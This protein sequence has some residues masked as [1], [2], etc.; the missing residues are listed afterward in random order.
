MHDS[1]V[2]ANTDK[3][4]EEFEVI[5]DFEDTPAVGTAEK[6]RSQWSDADPAQHDWHGKSR[7]HDCNL[8]SHDRRHGNANLVDLRSGRRKIDTRVTIGAS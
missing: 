4:A 7:N 6:L 2:K 5:D 8:K 1:W 3:Q